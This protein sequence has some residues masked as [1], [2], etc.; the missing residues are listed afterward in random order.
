MF[1]S[2]RRVA[3]VAVALVA[4]AGSF[5]WIALARADGKFERATLRGLKGVQV[6]VEELRPE[7]ERAGLKKQQLQTDVE[8]RLRKAGIRVLTR[9]E[10]LKTPGTPLL[11]LNVNALTAVDNKAV[12]FGISVE[13][14]QEVRLVRDPKIIVDATTWSTD[15]VGIA[16]VN[17]IR[18]IRRRVGDR[19]D[20]FINAYLAMNPKK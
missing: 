2:N 11:Y 18:D 3:C 17:N 16:D 9:K 4:L 1:R 6:V 13:L 8:L 7:I 10:R 20:V 12:V 14:N 15:S 5:L 19:V